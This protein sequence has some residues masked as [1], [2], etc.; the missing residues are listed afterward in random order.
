MSQSVSRVHGRG[1]RSPPYSVH[2][3]PAPL[4]SNR[5]LTEDTFGEQS[6]VHGTTGVDGG[7][8]CFC[9]E[10]RPGRSQSLTDNVWWLPGDPSTACPFDV[11]TFVGVMPVQNG[12]MF[13]TGEQKNLR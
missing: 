13:V 3:N 5:H 11:Q 1:G 8:V 12:A 6:V 7:I 4:P 10:N 9:G 2:I